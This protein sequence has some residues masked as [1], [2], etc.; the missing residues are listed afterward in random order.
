MK[1]RESD[2]RH[3]KP[4]LNNRELGSRCSK[5]LLLC[6]ETGLL[7]RETLLRHGKRALL[8]RKTLLRLLVLGFRLHSFI[9]MHCLSVHWKNFCSAR[10]EFNHVT[11]G[12]KLNFWNGI[13]HK[14]I[15][16]NP[17]LKKQKERRYKENWQKN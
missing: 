2:L 6:R 11:P 10:A 7:C 17:T 13:A 9:S 3:R 1:G 16:T 12:F 14:I 8:H 15:T 5:S 4:K